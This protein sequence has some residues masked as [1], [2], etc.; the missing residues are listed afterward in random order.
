MKVSDYIVNFIVNQGIHDIFGYQGTMIAHFVDSIYKNNH[1]KNHTC[2]NEQGA[3]FAAVGYA[4]ASDKIGV[5]YATSGPGAMNL[6]SGIA[7]AYFDS[8]PTVF[9]TGQLNLYEYTNIPTLR[10]QGFQELDVI[11]SVKSYTKYCTQIMDKNDI[12]YE[13]EKAFYIAQDGRKGPVVLDIPMNIQRE[14][15]ELNKLKSFQPK[16]KNI[17][18]R[19][20][21]I[22]ADKIL[23]N[24]KNAERPLLLIGNGVKK[25]SNEHKLI[26]E[27]I[28]KLNIPTITSLPAR[29]L[30][31]INDNLFFGY[32]GA[33]YGFREA[34]IIAYKKT[35][36]IIS[37]GC[38]MCKR[39]I[40]QNNENFAK[41]AKII[42]IDFDKEELKRKV[43]ENELSYCIDYQG[44]IKKLIEKIDFIIEKEWLDTCLFIKN[45]MR[46]FDRT[47]KER[48]INR[49]MNK[50]SS[51]FNEN[52]S[53]FVDVGQ[54][55][56]WAAQS[57]ET[58][59][60]QQMLFSGGHGAM[61]FSIPAAIGGYYA[62]GNRCIA[63]CGDGSIQM[64]I[65]E[66]QWI[67]REQ[68]PIFIFVFNNES[69][70][71]IRQQQNDFFNRLYYGSNNENGYTVPSFTKIAKAYSLQSYKVHN[72]KELHNAI[73]NS[74]KTKPCL[75]EILVD[76]NSEAFP[77][78]FFGEEMYNQRP[79]LSKDIMDKILKI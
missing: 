45:T 51:Y 79:Y 30:F 58:K 4:K 52:L 67:F 62:T 11:S 15:I 34:N 69:L 77:K 26:K 49:I 63:L 2:Y 75:F 46:K 54:H 13:L 78:T 1:I 7:D 33:A 57:Y 44:V 47:L 53:V 21:D 5:A 39:Q 65:Q 6:M 43:H 9:I 18:N 19:Q 48:N 68:I 40:G 59:E 16:I 41:N 14:E 42:R 20:Y 25:N 31:D 17:N 55:Q 12:R 37:I 66:L 29:H 73:N 10:Q 35:D 61:G 64:N 56:M 71:L 24:I 38:S 50:I 23:E 72:E 36:L 76:I 60:N 28:E 70:G 3:A 74:D 22:I 27:L 32:I 8:I